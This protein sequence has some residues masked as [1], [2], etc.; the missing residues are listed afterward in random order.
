MIRVLVAED[1]HMVRGALVALLDLEVD[2]TVVAQVTGGDEI[3][4]AATESSAEVAVID[5]DLPGTDG[6]TAAGHLHEYLPA[7]RTLILTSIDRPAT[8]KRA[9]SQRVSGFLLKDAPAGELAEAIR[10]VAIGQ[11]AIS[12][13]LALGAWDAEDCPLTD[14]ERDVLRMY[15]TGAEVE[16]I[17]TELYLAVGTVR[18]HLTSVRTK[19]NARSR[20]DAV[21][22]AESSGWI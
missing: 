10:R 19:L 1:M 17:G 12:P 5:I 11:R 20:V 21:R 7:C 6:L 3:L 15:S 18:N 9:L 2:I 8:V 22:I 16:E 13:E 4:G 14:R